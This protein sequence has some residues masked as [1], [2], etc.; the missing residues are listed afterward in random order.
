MKSKLTIAVL[1]LCVTSVM[2]QLS[3]A[4][5]FK[6][7]LGVR[8]TN[9]TAAIGATSTPNTGGIEWINK[10]GL[11]VAAD[12]TWQQLTWTFGTDSVTNFASGMRWS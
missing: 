7:S 12:G 1:S 5:S 4:Q 8:E 9:S 11:T 2:S 6:V 10:D 3:F